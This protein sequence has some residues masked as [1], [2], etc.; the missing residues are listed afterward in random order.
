M[1]KKGHVNSEH[2]KAGMATWRADKI[3]FKKEYFQG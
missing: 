3:D 2:K 1:Y